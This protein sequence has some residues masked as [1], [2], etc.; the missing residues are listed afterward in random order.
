MRVLLIASCSLWF[1]CADRTTAMPEDVVQVR[2]TYFD[3]PE[4]VPAPLDILFVVDRSPAMAVHA[5]RLAA[6]VPQFITVLGDRAIDDLHLGVITAD[7]GGTGCG[8]GE[9][10][11]MRHE[12]LVG[13]PFII[14]WEHLDRSTSTNYQGTLGA[15]FTQ[16][17]TVGHGGCADQRPFDA[18]RLALENPRNVGFHRPDAALAIVLISGGD[19][20]S[21]ISGDELAA[22]LKTLVENPASL[23]VSGIYELGSPRLDA[24]FT[25]FPGRSTT[26][27]IHQENLTDAFA[28]LSG[29]NGGWGRSFGDPCMEGELADVDPETPGAQ[30]DCSI[31]DVLFDSGGDR[32]FEQTITECAPGSLVRPCWR[33]E[34]DVQNCPFAGSL[35]VRIDRHDWAAPG[36]HVIGYCVTEA[37]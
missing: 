9:G 4:L 14:H 5:Q 24:F 29:F 23:I 35:R 16:I 25:N 20:R 2:V 18:I 32:S 34:R 6:N 22:Y 10:G 12:G 1:A 11:V 28:I 33:F 30:Y 26:T 21:Q 37:P 8:A 27:T 3:I 19:D 15:A 17:A 31:S 36:T 13:S 7:L